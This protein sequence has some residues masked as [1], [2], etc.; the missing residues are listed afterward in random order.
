MAPQRWRN[1]ASS[2]SASGV[3]QRVGH[4]ETGQRTD[5]IDA[6]GVAERA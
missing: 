4:I 3:P 1:S 2:R 5:A 6:V